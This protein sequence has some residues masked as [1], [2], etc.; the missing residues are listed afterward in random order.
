MASCIAGEKTTNTTP[1]SSYVASN[2]GQDDLYSDANGQVFRKT[3]SGWQQ[4]KNGDWHPV[5]KTDSEYLDQQFKARQS[6][7]NNYDEYLRQ[8][9]Q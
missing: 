4:H 9:S 1:G 8:R 7:Y 3:N 5:A 6:G 2:N